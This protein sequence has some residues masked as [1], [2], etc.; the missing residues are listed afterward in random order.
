MNHFVQIKK[1]FV[2][3]GRSDGGWAV[4]YLDKSDGSFW[5]LTYPNSS[6]HGGG[7]PSIELLSQGEVTNK[8]R[9]NI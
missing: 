4:L 6:D 1:E 9:L 5:E 3:I 8:Y 2:E 7:E